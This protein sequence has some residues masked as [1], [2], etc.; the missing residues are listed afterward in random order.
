MSDDRA[1]KKTY[2]SVRIKKVCGQEEPNAL[3]VCHREADSDME[4]SHFTMLTGILI[5]G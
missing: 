4:V 3:S 2:L 1:L 5:T